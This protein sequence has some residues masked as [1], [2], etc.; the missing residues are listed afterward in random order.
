GVPTVREADGLALSSRNAYLLADERARA[1]A[2][3]NALKSARSAIL[4]GRPVAIALRDAKQA[5]VDAGFLRI[6]YLALV[7]AQTLEPVELPKAG[8]RLIAAA[9]IGSTRLI[10]NLAI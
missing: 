3:P 10:D 6:D 1:V 2:L 8:M 7:D 4:G 5:L 9:V